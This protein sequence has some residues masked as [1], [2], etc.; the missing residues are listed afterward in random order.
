MNNLKVLFLDIEA[1]N[2][3]ASVG[4][5]L[6]IGYKWAHEKKAKVLDLSTHPGSKTTD[7]RNLLKAFEPIFN[8]A[9]IVVHHFGQYYD[10]PFLQTRRL[11][12]GMKPLPV[13]QQVD[14]W[15]IAKKRLKF[16]SNRLDAI[17]KALHCP[18]EKTAIDFN[19][20]IDASAGDRKALKYISHHCKMD[21]LVLEWVYNHI[22]AV[23]DQHPTGILSNRTNMCKVCKKG[24]MISNGIRPT[25]SKIYRRLS[26]NKCGFTEKGKVI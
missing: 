10:V 21:V 12:H 19:L 26:C 22:K 20:W 5:V 16:H 2:L 23:W 15:R 8:E 24:N 17:L 9:D 25:Q 18:Y 14:T 4:Y 3:S 11:I 1:S 6:S 13:V 7:D